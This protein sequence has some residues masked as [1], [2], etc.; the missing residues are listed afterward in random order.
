[1]SSC[2][3]DKNLKIKEDGIRDGGW[4]IGIA[5]TIEDADFLRAGPKLGRGPER[6]KPKSLVI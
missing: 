1:M 5:H 4:E 3:L 6:E 2:I